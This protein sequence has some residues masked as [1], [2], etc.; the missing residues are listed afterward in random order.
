MTFGQLE[1]ERERSIGNVLASQFDFNCFMQTGEDNST[2]FGKRPV[3][4]S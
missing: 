1:C 2:I 4:P 3:N